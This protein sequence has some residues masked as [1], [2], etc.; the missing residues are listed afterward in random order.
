MQAIASIPSLSSFASTE[1][2]IDFY[3]TAI[4][5][6]ETIAS[7]YWQLGIAYLLADREDDARAAWFIPISTA[8]PDTIDDLSTQLVEALDREAQEQEEISELEKSWLLRQHIQALTPNFVEN[9]F[10]AIY[11]SYITDR[12]TPDLLLE[13]QV[14]ELVKTLSPGC[15]DDDL[16][17]RV[18]ESLM[19]IRMDLGLKLIESCL[20]LTGSKRL[21]IIDKLLAIAQGLIDRLYLYD[22]VTALVEI[23]DRIHPDTL[24][25]LRLLSYVYCKAENYPPAIAAAEKYYQ[26]ASSISDRLFGSFIAQRACFSAGDW[27]RTQVKSEIH[28]QLL[29]ETIDLNPVDLD[30]ELDRHLSL[31]SFFLPYLND[32]PRHNRVLQNQIASIYQQN[33]RSTVNNI[34]TSSSR[35]TNQSR[36]LHI[37]YVASTLTNHSVGWLCRW[38][39]HYH[40]RE[41]FKIFLYCVNTSAENSFNHHWFRDKVEHTSYFGYDDREI[42]AQIR[43]DEIDILIDLDSITFDRTCMVMAEKPAPIQVSWLGWDASGL[44]TIDYFI[45]DPYVLPDNAQDYYQEKLWRLPQTY[46]GIE[47][48]EVG[49]PNITRQDLDIP[50]DAVVYFSS[51]AGFKRHPDNI[52]C[53]MKIIAAVPNSYLLI[54]GKSDPTIVR[55]LFGKIAQEEGISIDRLRFLPQAPTE[56][57][58]RANLTIA[59]I[60][61]DTFPYNG[62]T[63]TLETLWMGIPMVTQ[64]GKQ[65][66]ARNSYT[67]MLNAGIEEGIAWNQDEYVEWGIKLGLDPKL[68]LEIREKLRAG[69]QTAPVWN[70]KQF[71]LDM[72]Q[73]YR[74]IWAKYQSENKSNISDRYDNN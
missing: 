57:I 52:R 16:L 18:L 66:A 33:V 28:R 55:N 31:T 67:F 70:A 71:A 23:C 63:T 12:L 14:L 61:L 69:R 38:L 27:E 39:I 32:D 48:F 54:K 34:Q 68:R 50:S 40:D 26:L 46:L 6:D 44:P 62:A 4:D 5:R 3:E 11:L 29:A 30:R 8:E 9:I 7:N 73:A 37:G 2:A 65:F 72:E 74:E 22:F 10:Q 56:Y 41:S 47:G 1:N 19:I 43:A 49:I 45:V 64:V 42:T 20:L 17:D 21:A 53:Q 25:I 15:I 59:D 35:L 36:R 24:C 60:V 13:W 51:Q 58:H